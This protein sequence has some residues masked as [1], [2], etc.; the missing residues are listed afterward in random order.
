MQNPQRDAGEMTK[1]KESVKIFCCARISRFYINRRFS[2]NEH[3][4][5]NVFL[6]KRKFEYYDT[7]ESRSEPVP[8][9]V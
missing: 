5:V 6:V 7:V 2:E 4:C 8:S 9:V 3:A 1:L